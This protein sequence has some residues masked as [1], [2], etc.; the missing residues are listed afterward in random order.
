[1]NILNVLNYSPEFGGG[2]LHHLSALGK[3]CV[4]KGDKL[5]IAFPKEREWQKELFPI[6]EVIIIP[7]ILNPLLSGYTSKLRKFCKIHSIEIIHIHF[8]FSL[9]FSLAFSIRNFKIPIVYHWHN[10]PVALIEFLTQKNSLTGK[11]RRS[12]SR[13]IARFTDIMVI[14]RHISMSKEISNLLVNN[15]WTQQNKLVYLPNGIAISKSQNENN[16]EK[17]SV[18]PIIGTVANFRPQKDHETLLKAFSI[19]L[20]TGIQCELWIIG[21]GPTKRAM[22]ML[23]NQLGIV[24]FVRFLGIVTDPSELFRKFEVFVL[25]T[26]YEGHP[27]VILEAMSF[28]VP[29]VATRISSIPEIITNGENGLLVSPKDPDDLARAIKDILSDR[30]LFEKLSKAATGSLKNQ[31]TVD[32]WAYRVI[33]IYNSVLYTKEI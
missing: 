6:C 3:L 18:V 31:I 15:K 33:S 27:L 7:E 10:P 32:E 12:Y 26:N 4:E 9:A 11:F 16:K 17:S 30:S 2:I 19:L 29:I 14:N 13:L 22:E 24:S 25:S 8:T 28:G 5:Y 20:K 1:M 21:D 23:A